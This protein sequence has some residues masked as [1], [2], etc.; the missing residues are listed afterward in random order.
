MNTIRIIGNVYTTVSEDEFTDAFI[1]WLES[2]GWSF[3]GR[4]AELG[5]EDD[6]GE[7][8]D[9]ILSEEAVKDR[10]TE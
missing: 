10:E 3:F 9:G 4:T 7:I 1:E 8:L 2:K 6:D 5:D